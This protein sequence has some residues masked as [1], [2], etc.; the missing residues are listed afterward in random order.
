MGS[1]G[2][3]EGLRLFTATWS[4]DSSNLGTPTLP[5]GTFA[6]MLG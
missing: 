5:L 6:N 2:E 4:T 3:W 1:W